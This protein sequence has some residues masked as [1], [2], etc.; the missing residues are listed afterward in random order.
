MRI[1]ILILAHH[2][3]SMLD[4][5]VKRLSNDFDVYIHLDKKGGIPSNYFNEYHN[6]FVISKYKVNWGSYNQIRAT[7][8][9]FSYSY[10]RDYDYYILISGQDIPLKSNEQIKIFFKENKG[11]S[12]IH[13][14]SL[15]A[16]GWDDNGGLDRVAYYWEN[17]SE[18]TYFGNKQKNIIKFIR[19]LQKK[20]NYKRALRIKYYG[21]ANWVNLN[22]A[23]MTYI[24]NYLNLQPNYLKSFKFTKCADEI[25]LQ[26]I[27]MNS[28]CNII[29]TPLRYV[30]WIQG[31]EKPRVLR[32]ND[33]EKLKKSEDLFARKF[34]NL[35]D[36]TIIAELYDLT[37]EM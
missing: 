1:A 13:C 14:Y 30:D 20:F 33:L 17:N 9:L 26:T 5:L 11:R 15:P 7:V 36:N 25:W 3:L 10:T 2:N 19:H 23:C 18:S 22:K 29:P 28:D 24:L 37:K 35:I 4:A 21:G 34:D 8:A 27:V 32:L 31:P 16:N 6:V 12:Y